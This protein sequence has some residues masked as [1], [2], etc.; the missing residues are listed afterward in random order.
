MCLSSHLYLY[1]LNTWIAVAAASNPW[2]GAAE[3]FYCITWLYFTLLLLS[4]AERSIKSPRKGLIY[5]SSNEHGNE[6]KGEPSQES[7]H[8]KVI[9]SEN[10]FCTF[11]FVVFFLSHIFLL[12]ELTP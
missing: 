10:L 4:V 2:L 7:T 9:T 3:H 8:R 6:K 5:F 12:P 1:T 11:L